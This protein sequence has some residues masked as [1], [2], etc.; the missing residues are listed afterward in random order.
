[1][2][3][4]ADQKR[5]YHTDGICRVIEIKEHLIKNNNREALLKHAPFKTLGKSEM[6][7]AE[8]FADAYVKA[9]SGN[10][11]RDR[12]RSGRRCSPHCF[13]GRGRVSERQRWLF[14]DHHPQH[15]YP[16]SAPCRLHSCNGRW[17]DR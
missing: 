4:S 12:L 11:R 7:P 10:L 16:G 14:T 8:V 1:M 17:K 15:P 9:K 6:F 5:A 13:K 2:Q 3:L